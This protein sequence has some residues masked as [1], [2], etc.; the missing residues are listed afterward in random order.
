MQVLP[1]DIL[2]ILRASNMVSIHNFTLGGTIRTRLL[3]FTQYALN[4][5]H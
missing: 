4:A 3:T 1:P 5:L 2:F